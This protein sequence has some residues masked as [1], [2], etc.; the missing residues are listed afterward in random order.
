MSRQW[1][2]KKATND[3]EKQA[4]RRNRHYRDTIGAS[5]LLKRGVPLG[6][7]RNL[8]R[9]GTA[10]AYRA[11]VKRKGNVEIGVRKVWKQEICSI[12]VFHGGELL[13]ESS[14]RSCLNKSA[15]A[16][17]NQNPLFLVIGC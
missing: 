3:R 7:R 5:N 16:N 10:T 12:A 6:F 11:V 13:Q 17:R 8:L 4:K 9:N 1:L 15:H 2:C 14:N